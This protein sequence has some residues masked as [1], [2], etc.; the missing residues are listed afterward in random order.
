MYT[1]VERDPST[2]SGVFDAQ[3]Q[4]RYLLADICTSSALS[5]LRRQP[6]LS[7][8]FLNIHTVV[9]EGCE[10]VLGPGSRVWFN[11][12][13]NEGFGRWLREEDELLITYLAKTLI[14]IQS[15]YV[16]FLL[17]GPGWDVKQTQRQY[18]Y[19]SILSYFYS[20]IPT[21]PVNCFKGLNVKRES[22]LV[23]PACVGCPCFSNV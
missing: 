3:Y 8:L 23:E 11:G 14:L 20:G 13:L 9:H 4:W 6:F 1:W 7:V 17:C 22:K 10:S 16:M 18:D 2:Y 19:L 15:Y 21:P 5:L 12:D